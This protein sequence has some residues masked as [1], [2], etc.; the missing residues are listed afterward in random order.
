MTKIVMY[1]SNCTPSA[2]GGGQ[3]TSHEE[4][5]ATFSELGGPS[6]PKAPGAFFAQIMLAAGTC[7]VCAGCQLLS[8]IVVSLLISTIHF[9]PLS[10]LFLPSSLYYLGPFYS[11]S[12]LLKET[13]Y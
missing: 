12:V 3:Y 5:L 11:R 7:S 10:L 8:L 13:E 2:G 9:Y 6:V 1:L 4:P